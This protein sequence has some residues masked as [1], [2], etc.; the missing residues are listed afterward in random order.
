MTYSN[1]TGKK[2]FPAYICNASMG[3]HTC[4]HTHTELGTM[5]E[6]VRQHFLCPGTLPV[7]VKDERGDGY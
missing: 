3:T 4:I 6:D 1:T 2:D 5:T 7:C